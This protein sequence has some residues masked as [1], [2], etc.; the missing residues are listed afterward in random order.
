MSM[1][2]KPLEHKDIIK[3][4]G[5]LKD[6]T[7]EYPMHLMSERKAAFLQKAIDIKISKGDDSSQD[8]PKGGKAGSGGVGSSGAALRDKPFFLGLSLNQTI[9]IGV[10]LILLVAGYFMRDQITE[11]LVEN[12]IINVEE[13]AAPANGF[14]LSGTPTKTP[15]PRPV[16]G[17]PA[18]NNQNEHSIVENPE[19]TA[20]VPGRDPG[21][22][23]VAP[24]PPA[25]RGPASAFRFLFCI[26]GLGGDT[27]E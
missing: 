16:G 9:T 4:L 10:I 2:N 17:A 7:P 11:V 23:T 12:E 26:L 5:E 8:G 19:S 21:P 15:T 13:T 25:Q 18:S 3:M 27:C 6:E 1:A 14:I 22:E 24:T 20:K